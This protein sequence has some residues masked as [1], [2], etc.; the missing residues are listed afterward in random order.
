M[1]REDE[2]DKRI[3]PLLF[4]TTSKI[5]TTVGKGKPLTK[6]EKIR[7]LIRIGIPLLLSALIVGAAFMFLLKDFGHLYP[8]RGGNGASTAVVSSEDGSSSKSA[9]TTTTTVTHSKVTLPSSRVDP[10]CSAHD[11]C[12]GLLDNCC[13]TNGTSRLPSRSTPRWNL[14]SIAHVNLKLL[15]PESSCRWILFGLLQL[16]SW[17]PCTAAYSAVLGRGCWKAAAFCF[18]F[19]QSTT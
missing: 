6:E 2:R 4:A 3:S 12:A 15:I 7:K 9:A 11:A 1:F 10:R 19:I 16:R 18:V 17:I 5:Y 14:N 13:P 8:G